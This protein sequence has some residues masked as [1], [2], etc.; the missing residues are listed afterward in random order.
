MLKRI[1]EDPLWLFDISNPKALLVV[2]HADDE[3]IFA[4]GLILS[5]CKTEWTI[6]CCNPQGDI[7]EKEFRS[8]CQFLS[9]KSRNSI[10]PVLLNPIRK[11]NWDIEKIPP[12]QLKP[13]AKGYNFVLTHNQEGE[14]GNEDHREVHRAVL[15]SIGNSNTW[16]FLS[17][18]SSNIAHHTQKALRSRKPGGNF[19]LPLS[20][21][22][23]RLKIEAFQECHTSQAK[24]YGYVDGK[25]RNSQLKETLKWE[26]ES[27]REEYAFYK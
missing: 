1:R 22:I 26:F 11:H 21:E 23:R 14:Y 12:E 10:M 20:P 18:G 9:E 27:G 5:S 2:A 17:S 6:I 15:D 3:T 19:M 7:R 8:A 25:L 13:Y 4:G 24:E 16:V